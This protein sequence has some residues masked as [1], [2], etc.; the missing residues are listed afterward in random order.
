MAGTKNYCMKQIITF[1]F[2]IYCCLNI[3]AQN[4]NQQVTEK[5]TPQNVLNDFII[6]SDFNSFEENK[7]QFISSEYNIDFRSTP[8]HFVTL[9]SKWNFNNHH[10]GEIYFRVEE[11]NKWTNWK[12]I[13]HDHHLHEDAEFEVGQLEFLDK[14]I[15]KFQFKIDGISEL[16]A[17]QIEFR[18]Y[19]PILKAVKDDSSH[20]M[21]MQQSQST[22]NCDQPSYKTRIQWGCPDGNSQHNCNPDYT[23]PTHLI[24]HHTAGVDNPPYDAV[25]NAYWYDHVFNRGWCDLGYNFMIAPDGTFYE[26]RAGGNNVQGA[27][28]CQNNYIRC[29]FNG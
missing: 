27:H 18:F 28:M 11:N 29:M 26:G 19:A 10:A 21:M 24:V 20:H 1:L 4:N 2:I 22:C 12:L 7:N 25:I 9:S 14:S 23:I 3:T 13:K 5:E 8:D 16:I 15:S 17:D 6:K